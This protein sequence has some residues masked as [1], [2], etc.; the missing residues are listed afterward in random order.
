[1][2]TLRELT[3]MT[4]ANHLSLDPRA[5]YEW[6]KAIHELPKVE[7]WRIG[8]KGIIIAAPYPVAAFLTA[9]ASGAA[10][11][12]AVVVVQRYFRLPIA[13]GKLTTWGEAG[14]SRKVAYCPL[15]GQRFFGDTLVTLLSRPELARK[16]TA[17]EVIQGYPAVRVT[18][19]RGRNTKEVR[20]AEAH[21]SQLARRYEDGIVVS[22]RISGGLLVKL[23]ELIAKSPWGRALEVIN[24]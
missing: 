15:T 24:D 2:T 17:I 20:F 14:G 11:R 9:M 8:P 23:A 13:G 19:G 7:R 16:V 22:T 3:T 1:M 5:A 4:A 10:R 21:A 18:Y 12:E 6:Q